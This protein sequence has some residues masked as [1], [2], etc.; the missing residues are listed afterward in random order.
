M[1]IRADLIS[2]Q[3]TQEI[4]NVHLGS[5]IVVACG[6]TSLTWDWEGDIPEVK[7]EMI[8][9]HARPNGEDRIEVVQD[10]TKEAIPNEG[11]FEWQTNC[12]AFGD[13]HS[14]IVKESSQED[15]E[16]GD[17]VIEGKSDY[18]TVLGVRFLS[19]NAS[20]VWS[21]WDSQNTIYWE[22]T[23]PLRKDKTYTLLI[24]Y[25]GEY[26]PLDVPDPTKVNCNDT[27]YLC[28]DVHSA[29]D[30]FSTTWLPITYFF[31]EGQEV[32]CCEQDNAAAIFIMLTHQC[33]V[34]SAG[35]FD[36]RRQFRTS[37]CK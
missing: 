5:E 33:H 10:L 11:I 22:D 37:I 19:P 28:P 15:A 23:T 8:Q 24:D 3:S 14:I 29:N 20:S 4:R 31:Q 17:A 26:T 35:Q 12:F 32:S 1:Y 18:F 30:V 2:C 6:K 27:P 36:K 21:I 7:L 16:N 9:H 13:N 34:Y 25:E